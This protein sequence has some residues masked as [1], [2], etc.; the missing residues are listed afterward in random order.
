[1]VDW[2]RGNFLGKGNRMSS[3]GDKNK[4][5]LVLVFYYLWF[6]YL[7]NEVDNRKYFIR[8]LNELIFIK[9]VCIVR[10]SISF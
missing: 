1:M 5:K 9:Y 6:F 10:Y 4:N 7:Y 2:E 8:L 3:F